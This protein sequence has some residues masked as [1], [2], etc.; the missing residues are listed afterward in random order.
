[1]MPIPTDF[2]SDNIFATNPLY[3]KATEEKVHFN[4]IAPNITTNLFFIW[5]KYFKRLWKSRET[6][7]RKIKGYWKI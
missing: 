4:Y 5:E 1:M 7:N 2:I 3:T 6:K